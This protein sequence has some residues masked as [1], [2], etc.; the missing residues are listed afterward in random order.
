[1]KL[2]KAMVNLVLDV[3]IGLAFVVEAV[4]GFVLA[5]VLPHGGYQGGA[6]PLYGQQFLV[7]RDAWLVM[8]DWGAMIMTAGIL[9][10]VVLHWRWITCMLGRLW[11]DAFSTAEGAEGAEG[12]CPVEA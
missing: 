1:M 9:I 5:I 6:N 2:T 3:A 4:T 10:H 8:H 11:H 7:S 12:E